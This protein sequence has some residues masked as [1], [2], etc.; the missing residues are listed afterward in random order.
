MA[1]GMLPFL[2]QC[3]K[4]RCLRCHHVG[5]ILPES[6]IADASN[7]VQSR[8]WYVYHAPLLYRMT[9][10]NAAATFLV[11]FL[12]GAIHC[13]ASNFHDYHR[14]DQTAITSLFDSPTRV[15]IDM[16]G[17]WEY[18]VNGATEG[19]I[20]LPYSGPIRNDVVYRRQIRIEAA[21]LREHTWHMQFLG[22]QDE[23][24]LRING[25]SVQKYPGGM[26]PFSVRIPD[27]TLTPGMNTVELVVTQPGVKTMLLQR[28]MRTGQRMHMGVIREVF[29]VGTPH[30]WSSDLSVQ[31]AL[32]QESA[33]ISVAA[34]IGG[35]DIQELLKRRGL[36]TSGDR[37]SVSVDV[38]VYDPDGS[39]VARTLPTAMTIE[40][41]RTAQVRLSVGIVN[42]RRWSP[43]SPSL[44]RAEL[45][46]SLAGQVIDQQSFRVGIRT[47]SVGKGPSGRQL[48]VNDAP[49]F[50]HAIEYVESHPTLSATMT[51]Q[52]LQQDVSLLKTLGVNA[53]RVRHGAPHPLFAH[54]CDEY[55][56]MMLIE[57][58]AADIPSSLLLHEEVTARMRNLA[59][60]TVA[61]F[62]RFTA[63][64]AYGISSGLQESASETAA[65]HGPLAALFKR[66]GTKVL[67]K[68]IPSTAVTDVSEGGFDLIMLRCETRQDVQRLDE[69]LAEAKRTIRSA[70]VLASFGAGV[71]P[72]N[73]NG[74]SDPLSN[75]AQAVLIRDAYRVSRSAGAAGVCIWTFNDYFLERPTLLVDHHDAYVATSGIVDQWRQPRVAYTMLKSLINDE[76]EPLLQARDVS[77]DTPLVFIVTGLVIALLFV[78]LG[79]RSRRF[80]EYAL[81]AMLRPY[82]FYADIRDQRI[83][84]TVQTTILGVVIATSVGL[85]VATALYFLRTSSAF[86]YAMHLVI[87]SNAWYE[88]LRFVSWR[89]GFAVLTCATG[90]FAM[91]VVVA[92]MLRVGAMFIKGRIFFRDTLTIVVWSALPLVMLLP[93][94]VALYQLLST[95][96]ISLWIPLL[97]LGTAIWFCSRSLRATSVVFDVRPWIVYAIGG[98]CILVA[99]AMLF[100]VYESWYDASAFLQYYLAVVAL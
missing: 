86:E 2:L 46:I 12:A 75:Q 61:A 57:L 52:Q 66:S 39:P 91:L 38:V 48:F 9:R 84:S 22:V 88:L 64:I 82:N 36:G 3:G 44:Y 78:A 74:F 21:T 18:A 23:V 94:G 20:A 76:K 31:T 8:Q 24:E 62:D 68:V 97:L 28:A 89:P 79:N 10:L 73:S 11:V 37:T 81:R 63:V 27:R 59:E 100:G 53:V 32:Q 69:Y 58:P 70:A 51:A 50:V 1:N 45:R 34:L 96:S 93:L 47:V 99:A 56:I 7:T 92:S 4:D 42:P 90:V 65:F 35:G 49:V 25:R 6:R 19:T 33:T 26:V 85:V 77:V 16:S 41:S 72:A 15:V 60:R 54:L 80:R 67:Y 98:G 17:S 14:L 30:V 43:E 71:S 87:P 29:L 55:G 5:L 95:E 83:L 40:K 13:A